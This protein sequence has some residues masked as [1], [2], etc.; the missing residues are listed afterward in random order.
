LQPARRRQSWQVWQIYPPDHRKHI[1]G[2]YLAADIIGRRQ[3]QHLPIPE[4][5][6]IAR[7]IVRIAAKDVENQT[8][9][10]FF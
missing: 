7:V 6:M 1:A 4:G 10:Q 9:I 2:P 8:G 5:S 3:R